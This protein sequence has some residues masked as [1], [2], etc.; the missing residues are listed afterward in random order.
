MSG[1]GM[2]VWTVRIFGSFV[3]GIGKDL[4]NVFCWTSV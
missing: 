3:A 2:Q 4:V 1:R